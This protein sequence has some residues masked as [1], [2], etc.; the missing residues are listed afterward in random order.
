MKSLRVA[1]KWTRVAREGLEQIPKTVRSGLLEKIDALGETDPRNVHK[2]LKSPLQGCYSLK[3]S[4]FRAVYSVKEE[5]VDDENIL[6]Y[7]I[8]RFLIAGIKKEHS[9]RDMHALAKKLADLADL[10]FV[11]IPDY[12]ED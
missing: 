11:K 6:L 8:I 5:T 4:G 1:I 10:G 2:A 9:K 7:V 12:N 3:S